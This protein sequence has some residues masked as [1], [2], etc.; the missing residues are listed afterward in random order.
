MKRKIEVNKKWIRLVLLALL[1]L[2]GWMLDLSAQSD[3]K[4]AE[5]DSLAL[6]AFYWATDGPNWTS[7]QDGF[8]FDGLSSE[9]QD[10]YDGGFNKWLNG[11]IKDWEAVTVDSA[12][13]RV[14]NVVF[15]DMNLK[16]ALPETLGNITKMGGKIEIRNDSLLVGAV[17]SFLWRWTD[18]ERF[19]VKFSGF[20]SIDTD[21]MENMV[22]LTEFNTEGTPIAGTVPGIIF[23][24]SAMEKIYIHDSEYDGLPAEL[25]SISGLTRLYLNGNLLTSLPDMSEM[26]WGDGAKIRVQDNKLTFED[27]E[28]NM[29]V[30]SDMFVAEF[31][32]SPQANVGMPAA[33]DLMMGETLNLSVD[34]GGSANIYTW[35]TG[36]D[37][38]IEGATETTYQKEGV[39]VEDAL[40][41]KALI[42]SNL[43][44]GLDIFSEV[45]TS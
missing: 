4:L 17:P 20:T 12:T 41:Y 38:V 28:P 11:P 27:L 36:E 18:V 32:Y 3:Y 7:N 40:S 24:L 44:P 45:S 42:Q 6:V 9:W 5:Q 30:A 13:Q 22:N 21:G 37:T 25:T 10:R 26:T 19:Q 43:V 23:T 8:G 34:V 14:T 16:G 33:I 29:A 35:I 1:I 31:N 15:K 2:L 39:T